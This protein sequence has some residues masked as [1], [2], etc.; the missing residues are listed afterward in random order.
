MII[1]SY[2]HI[3]KSSYNDLKERNSRGEKLDFCKTFKHDVKFALQV[4]LVLNQK[5]IKIEWLNLTCYALKHSRHNPLPCKQSV[6]TVEN[7]PT[8]NKTM[9]LSYYDVN[10]QNI[11]RTRTMTPEVPKKRLCLE[12]SPSI[13]HSKWWKTLGRRLCFAIDHKPLAALVAGNSNQV[14]DSAI[15]SL[16]YR[17]VENMLPLHHIY[18]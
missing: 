17:C 1:T 16:K 4:V 11:K 8:A 3:V 7:W 5:K 14:H 2:H 6:Q 12:R 13:T 15:R 10:A 9:M 18:P